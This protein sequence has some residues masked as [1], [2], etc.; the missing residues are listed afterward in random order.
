[1][2][3]SLRPGN[4]YLQLARDTPTGRLI[5]E[6]Q[7]ELD[8]L[9]E[10]EKELLDQLRKVRLFALRQRDRLHHLVNFPLTP[11][12]ILPNELLLQIITL[13]LLDEFLHSD[14]YRVKRNLLMVS[15][16][17]R[18]LILGCPFL[19]THIRIS[20]SWDRSL[21]N[22]HIRRSARCPL[23]ITIQYTSAKPECDDLL[24]LAISSGDRWHS[25]VVRDCGKQTDRIL[26]RIG[27]T[28]SFPT[29]KHVSICARDSTAYPWFLRPEDAPR[30]EHVELHTKTDNR[31]VAIF[32]NLKTL[33][34]NS[35]PIEEGML[36]ALFSLQHLTA[37][38]LSGP[39]HGWGLLQHDSLHL[40][41]LESLTLALH[42]LGGLLNAIVAPRLSFLC[43]TPL[44]CVPTTV[45][46]FGHLPSKF[47]RVRHF[48]LGNYAAREDQKKGLD[49]EEALAVC[50]ASPGVCYAELGAQ[51]V[52][53]F[54][55]AE[56]PCPADHW[57]RIATLRI[58]GSVTDDMRRDLI[59]WLRRRPFKG[60][61]MVEVT[62]S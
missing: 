24:D 28:G 17:W 48:S 57:T 55:R 34:V 60:Q 21:V 56:G 37:L 41:L 4:P 38:S 46:V 47:P 26:Q 44:A 11:L 3:L 13:V 40:P 45:S 5:A 29:L 10:R 22:A 6:A 50:K 1:M 25:L 32:S 59:G 23:D 61:S 62:L 54:F 19:W 36:P 27:L 7:A 20:P 30:L 12:N 52:S 42:D 53:G 18:D 33:V 51:H 43:Y 35:P 9:R 58:L 15:R 14:P 49:A 39:T 31:V 8:D 16:R 2:S